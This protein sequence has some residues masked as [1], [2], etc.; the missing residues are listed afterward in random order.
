MRPPTEWTRTVRQYGRSSKDWGLSGAD[1]S[2]TLGSRFA[3]V[4]VPRARNDSPI[5]AR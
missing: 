1:R 4:H 3:S 5:P 2:A